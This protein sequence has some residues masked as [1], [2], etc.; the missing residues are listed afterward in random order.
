MAS[1]AAE[2]KNEL[3]RIVGEKNCCRR[4]ELTALLR[5]GAT[6][7]FGRERI[8]GITFANNN[9]AV[10]RK[11][12]TLMKAAAPTLPLEIIVARANRLRKRNSYIVRAKPA[13]AAENLLAAL[14]IVCGDKLNIASDIALLRRRCCQ[15]A[16]LA[17]AFL[18]GG[19]INRPES[20][21]HLEIA[22][23][24]FGTAEL[25]LT[26]LKR[27]DFPA[28]IF[29]RGDAFV[30]YIKECDAIIDFLAMIRAETAVEKFEV[31]RNVKEVRNQVNRIV[32]CETANL[33]KA[34][35]AAGKQLADIKFLER[36]G[37]FAAMPQQLAETAKMRMAN[38][39]A[40][41]A[42]LA[43]LLF[44]SKSGL[45]HRLRK[46]RAFAEASRNEK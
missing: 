41:M 29:E 33:Q 30:V 42:E 31:A 1:F 19:S 20:R 39:E 12:F 45:A 26:L 14:N 24:N 21:Y 40:S 23:E 22:T 11:T 3:S 35:N 6:I 37:L 13:P 44:V 36:E 46:I 27:M 7:S 4:A 32:N 43:A 38:P 8:F 34:V 5:M 15:T 18:G 17:G 25:L 28:N 16:Y 10:A 9:A 2:V